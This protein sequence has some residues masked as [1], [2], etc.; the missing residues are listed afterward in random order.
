MR[1]NVATYASSVSTNMSAYEELS[2]H[3]IFAIRNLIA[4]SPD[5]SY[6]ETAGSIA[7]DINFFM[8][9]FTAEEAVD[10]SGV[11]D[12]DTFWSFQ[13]AAAYCLTCSEDSSEGIT[14]PLGSASWSSWWTEPSRKHQA[15]TGIAG[16]PHLQTR[17]WHPHLRTKG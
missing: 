3:H 12:P 14:I 7:D 2:G 13:L 4:S 16:S 9:Y 15:T 10:Y 6:P 8:D 17:W 11:R 5:D 1:S